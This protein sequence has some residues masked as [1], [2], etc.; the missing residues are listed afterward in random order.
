MENASGANTISRSLK[1]SLTNLILRPHTII[2]ARPFAFIA[3]V[4]GGTYLTANM[5]DTGVSTTRNLPASHVTSGTAKFAASSAANVGLCIYKD[6]AFVRM[7]GPPGVVPRAVPMASYALFTLRDCLTIFASFNVPP[8]LGPWV[9]TRLSDEFKK[10]A[11]SGVTVAQFVAPA[12]VQAVSTPLHL[13]G[14]DL[15]NR[16]ST[17]AAAVTARER[18]LAVRRNWAVS[19]A[20][21]ICRIVPAFGV[22]GVV[23]TNLRKRFMT[24]LE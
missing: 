13:W 8:M 21:R 11:M 6:Q 15:Y 19:V 24:A 20:A 18:W 10:K 2:L 17:A 12:V 9:D 4:Y 22:G 1:T 7:F 23:N 3:M 5:L 14:L 16:P